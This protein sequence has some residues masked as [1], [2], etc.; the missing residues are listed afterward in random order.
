M[1]WIIELMLT[2]LQN[3]FQLVF[4]SDSKKKKIEKG[5]L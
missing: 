5:R 4:P 1:K 2:C 3:N